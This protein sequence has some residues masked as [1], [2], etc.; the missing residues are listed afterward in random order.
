MQ[1]GLSRVRGLRGSTEQSLGP[2]LAPLFHTRAAVAGGSCVSCLLGKLKVSA[3]WKCAE[4]FVPPAHHNEEEG[5]AISLQ[6]QDSF[7][8][9]FTHPY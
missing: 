2:P 1:K 5:E 3:S 9:L 6:P 7:A 4:R 8:E